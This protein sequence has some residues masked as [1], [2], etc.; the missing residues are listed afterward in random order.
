MFWPKLIA[1]VWFQYTLLALAVMTPLLLPGFVL[2]L[3][4]SFTPHL[5]WPTSLSNTYLFDA[6]LHVLNLAIPAQV[7]EKAILLAILVLS[8]V[9]AHKLVA[10]F[11]SGLDKKYLFWGA[12]F[13]GIFYMINPFVYSRFMAGQH[14]VLLGYAL[15]PFFVSALI[16]LLKNPNWKNAAYVA[17]WASLVVGASLHFAGILLVLAIFVAVPFAFKRQKNIKKV[18]A[19][20]LVA[21][22]I[23]VVI[24]AYWLLPTALGQ[25]DISQATARFDTAD[26]QAFATNG[27]G[28][29]GPLGNV[30]RLQGFWADAR[31]MYLLPQQQVPAW[32]VIMLAVWALVIVGAAK[33]WRENRAVAVGIGLAALTAIVL[34]ITPF[35]AWAAQYVPFIAGYREPQKFVAVLAIIYSVLG[36]IGS[37][38]LLK[39]LAK[40]Q[41]RN[42]LTAALCGLLILPIICTPTMLWGFSGQLSARDYP[43]DW[44]ETDQKLSQDTSATKVLFLPWHQYINFAFA[45][46]IIANPAPKFFA[47]PTVAGDN[48]EYMN[49]QPTV[50]N[51]FNRRVEQEILMSADHT[52]TLGERLSELGFSH[53]I[54]AK[55]YDYQNY[56][57]LDNQTDLRLISDTASL[58]LYAVVKE[59]Q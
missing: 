31:D 18:A 44:Y 48:P 28:A 30:V 33:L 27:Q 23:A 13:A 53:V 58:K 41:S 20:C 22:G 8:G 59:K 35:V 14:L 50:P 21:A 36:A 26:Y 11:A 42:V 6:F 29:L 43:A 51:A 52:T 47:K 45:D 7:I 3:D 1:S 4:L 12:Y 15:T 16:N 34:A 10:H 25:T 19:Y 40:N 32:G 46:R 49:I 54:L 38:V 17:V 55:D 37:A 57:Y 2:T 39:R 56:G 24:N 9:G 5:A